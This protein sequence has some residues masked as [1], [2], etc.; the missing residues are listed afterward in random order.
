MRKLKLQVQLSLDGYM[1]D[2]DG[3]TSW[4]NWNWGPTWHWDKTLQHRFV[5]LHQ[6]IDCVLLS[7][8]MAEEGFIN[9]W[10]R[11]SENMNDPQSPFATEIRKAQKVVFG[12]TI[13]QSIWANTT[14]ATA[15]LTEEIQYLKKQG[16]K[17]LIAYG[18][19]TFASSL[20]SA[21]L[22]DE[23]HLYIN[24]IL[25]GDGLTPFHSII[26]PS[27]LHLQSAVSYPCGMAVMQYERA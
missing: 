3:D 18:G 24:P 17:D 21:S 14:I 9:H 15:N 27:S 22:V 11:V 4:M 8:Q 26:K 16:G 20:L 10:T 2:T 7:R 19:V 12:T 6:S 5:K 1:A 23:F 25:L 13:K